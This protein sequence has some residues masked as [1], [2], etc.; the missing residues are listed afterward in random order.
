MTGAFALALAHARHHHARSLLFVALTLLSVS[1]PLCTN[2]LARGFAQ[3]L[4]ARA[5]STPLI[6]GAKGSRFDLVMCLLYFRTTREGP[7]KFAEASRIAAECDGDVVPMRVGGVARGRPVVGVTPEYFDIRQL[8]VVA[9]VLPQRTG[10]VV[11]GAE[12]AR[13]LNLGVGAMVCT[14]PV[15]MFN[16]AKS[17]TLQLRVVG[18]LAPANTT[19]DGAMFTDLRTI[20][21]IEGFGHAHASAKAMPE[22]MLIERGAQGTVISESLV[23]DD[24]LAPENAERFHF[25]IAE[26]EL[27]LSGVIVRPQNEK[28]LSLLKARVNTGAVLQAVS[29]TEVVEEM[30]TYVAR[31][32]GLVNALSVL[33][34]ISTLASLAIVSVLAA[35]IRE[36]EIM[37][38][39]RVGASPAF[40]RSMF[41]CE[42][43]LLIGAGVVGAVLLWLLV[44]GVDV[45]LVKLV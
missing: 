32:Q 23:A 6:L 39:E 5:A 30:L 31:I 43:L 20:W 37:T 10:E 26:T 15:E 3:A 45:D 11:L 41:A 28:E 9:G 22:S 33:L 36:R 44:R 4:R 27:P 19:D 1:V 17:A 7:L 2:E 21:A 13:A 35:K 24:V 8:T 40:V 12:V 25:H 16:V 38:L 34:G 42:L 14:D 18:V 29:P